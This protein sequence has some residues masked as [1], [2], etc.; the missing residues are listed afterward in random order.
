LTIRGVTILPL[1]HP[2]GASAWA[3]ARENRGKV[4]AALR[5]LGQWWHQTKSPT[6]GTQSDNDLAVLADHSASAPIPV[7]RRCVEGT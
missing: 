6:C 4:T 3:N 7:T 1:P 5:W 2:S